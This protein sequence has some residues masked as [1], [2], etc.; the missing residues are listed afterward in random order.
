MGLRRTGPLTCLDAPAA[1]ALTDVIPRISRMRPGCWKNGRAPGAQ[2]A[3]SPVADKNSPL[4]TASVE[5]AGRYL[6]AERGWSCREGTG[7]K[8]EAGTLHP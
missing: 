3:C 8:S 4:L 1:D 5:S 7:T 2:V 6:S